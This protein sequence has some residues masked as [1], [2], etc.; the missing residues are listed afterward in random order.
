MEIPNTFVSRFLSAEEVSEA[1]EAMQSALQQ[2]LGDA[3]LVARYGWGCKLHPDLYGA[4]IRVRTAGV[5]KLI[6]DSLRQQ[7]IIPGECDFHFESS[8]DQLQIVFCHEGHLH[9]G[10][11]DLQLA[12]R[13]VTMPTFSR[14]FIQ[15][16]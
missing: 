5:A 2:L 8:D 3:A 10:G 13:L 15:K 9:V 4:P 16:T 7:I 11:N 12:Q 1:M 6:G 14:F